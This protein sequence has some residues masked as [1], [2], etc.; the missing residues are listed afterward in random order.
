MSNAIWGFVLGII[1]SLIADLTWEYLKKN[2]PKWKRYI[3]RFRRELLP[4]T[5]FLI[6]GK[7]AVPWVVCSYGP[8]SRE[9]IK[10]HY[11]PHPLKRPP[12]IETL[13]RQKIREVKQR[14]AKGEPVPFN[15]LGY[16]LEKF[17]VGHRAGLHEEPVLH[18]SFRPTDYFTMLVT[19]NMLDEPIIVDNVKTTLRKRYAERVDLMYSPVPEFATHFG[20]GIMVITGDNKIIFSERGPT[21]VDAFVFFPSVAEGSSR[22]VDAGPNGGP[23]PYRTA[24][25]GIA[26]ELGIEVSPDQV[27][28]L[29]FGANAVLCEYALCG[30]VH[31]DQTEN[32]ILQIRSLGVPKDK[33]E[34]QKLHFVEFK[35]EPVAEF[36]SKNRPWSPFA[37]VCAVHALIDSYGRERLERAFAGK[38]I[39]LSQKLPQES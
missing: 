30:V 21:A 28:F 26:E 12:E 11:N 20:V 16:Q 10:I 31:V 23:D 27:K 13:Y 35:P 25:R 19:D 17:F 1:T 4:P 8:Y 39:A 2:R 33:W 3:K 14:E 24:V 29:S 22:P 38:E 6:V 34:S 32:E 5:G 9:N 7:T 18:L 37:V 36:M 15:G